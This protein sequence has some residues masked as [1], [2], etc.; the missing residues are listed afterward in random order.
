VSWRTDQVLAA[1]ENSYYRRVLAF[2]ASAPT[3]LCDVL[4]E[5]HGQDATSDS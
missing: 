5:E 2:S 3:C 1:A 4:A